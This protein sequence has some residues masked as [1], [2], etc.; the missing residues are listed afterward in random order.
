MKRCF[1][2]G[3]RETGEEIFPLLLREVEKHITAYGVTE[4]VVGNYGGFDRMAARA[5]IDAKQRH[6]HVSLSLLLPYHPAEH[7]VVLPAGFDDSYYPDGMEHT[8]RRFAIVQANRR[9]I[10]CSDYLIAYVW[11]PA[12]NAEKIL[13]YAQRQEQRGAIA[14]TVLPRCK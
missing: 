7:P 13:N 6:P 9:M 11:H 3:H 4:F 2:I 8:P 14:V 12:S 5:V 10:S 1:F